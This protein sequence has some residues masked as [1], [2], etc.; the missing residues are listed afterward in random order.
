MKS[1]ITE[2]GIGLGTAYAVMRDYNKST[3]VV[4]TTSVC[5]LNSSIYD[6]EV[7]LCSSYAGVLVLDIY[8]PG[9]PTAGLCSYTSHYTT[10]MGGSLLSYYY[11]ACIKI[12]E[13]NLLHIL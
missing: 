6:R 9:F 3:R 4:L 12:N 2:N 7:L 8:K 11:R 10:T 1:S 13:E 5:I